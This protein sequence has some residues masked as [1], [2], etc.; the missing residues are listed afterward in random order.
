MKDQWLIEGI[1]TTTSPLHIGDG[2]TASD[3]PGLLGRDGTPAEF[4]TVARGVDGRLLVPG[5]A[6][7]GVLRAR[8]AKLA[9]PDDMLAALTRLLGSRDPDSPDAVA[10]SVSF[11]DSLAEA[12]SPQWLEQQAANLGAGWSHWSSTDLTG[13]AVGI[14]IDRKTRS[15]ADSVLFN[16]EVVPAGVSFRLRIWVRNADEPSVQCLLSLLEELN[17]AE[18][19]AALGAETHNGWGRGAWKRHSIRRVTTS[20]LVAWVGNPVP[21]T[22]FA[23]SLPDIASTLGPV[24][25]MELRR[26]STP[27]IFPLHLRFLGPFLVNRLNDSNRVRAEEKLPEDQRAHAR[28][29]LDSEG[30]AVLDPESF[31]GAL[32]SHAEKIIRTVAGADRAQWLA[33]DPTSQSAAEFRGFEPDASGRAALTDSERRRLVDTNRGL[34]LVPLLFGA[35]GWGSSVVVTEPF[36]SELPT[37]EFREED[38]PTNQEVHFRH[39]LERTAIDRF[40]G[41][42]HQK[43]A[44]EY[45]WRPFLKGGILIDVERWRAAGDETYQLGVALL[46]FVLRDL[47]QGEIAFGYGTTHDFGRAV[48]DPETNPKVVQWLASPEVAHAL[49]QFDSCFHPAPTR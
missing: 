5:S 21:I 24:P 33:P 29:R 13:I 18:W 37:R 10:G 30:K 11:F 49:T 8:L 36:R 27:L 40:T 39:R 20:D 2:R 48:L 7:K 28:P 45:V 25:G 31:R 43:F 44:C 12:P 9:I 34:G 17:R 42:V 14:G 15:V 46:A 22:Q 32:R 47:M 23:A 38:N 26:E 19:P 4:S 35:G 6:L 1:W 41:G 3:R 16:C